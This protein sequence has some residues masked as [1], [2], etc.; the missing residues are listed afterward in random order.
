MNEWVD[1]GNAVYFGLFSS[2]TLKVQYILNGN[3]TVCLIGGVKK[4]AHMSV[5]ICDPLHWLPILF[6]TLFIMRNCLV[7]VTPTY[8]KSFC[9]LFS[10]LH[11][12]ASLR[13]F[14]HD[15]LDIPSMCTATA[16]SR[17]FAYNGISAWNRLPQSQRMESLSLLS[18]CGHALRLSCLLVLQALTPFKSAV[19]LYFL[20]YCI[21]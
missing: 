11:A 4:C 16:Q 6:R 20:L 10:S 8:M 5:F 17:S 14:N 19:D 15:L 7:E 3:A 2:S 21:T 18:S 9:Y 1:F 12:R 13:S